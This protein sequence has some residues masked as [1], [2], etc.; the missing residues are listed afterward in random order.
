VEG[1]GVDAG[2]I[3]GVAIAVG[4]DVGHFGL[5]FDG[6]AGSYEPARGLIVSEGDFQSRL[7]LRKRLGRSCAPGEGLGLRDH[8]AD[9]LLHKTRVADVGKRLILQ[10][11]QAAVSAD[12]GELIFGQNVQVLAICNAVC[13]AVAAG[14][15]LGHFGLLSLCGFEP[16]TQCAPSG[17]KKKAFS[18][19]VSRIFITSIAKKRAMITV[20][21][22][23]MRT[24]KVI[25]VLLSMKE[26]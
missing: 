6:E 17:K 7:N 15:K 1:L 12:C 5:L 24:M 10:D 20:E 21:P 14:N 18:Y 8:I 13:V 4:D 26:R 19:W 3:D 23:K 2:R 25:G 22:R 16:H 11:D 9:L